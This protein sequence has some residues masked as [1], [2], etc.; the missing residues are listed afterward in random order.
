[1]IDVLSRQAIANPI[2][3]RQRGEAYMHALASKTLMVTIWLWIFSGS[4]ILFEPSFYEILLLPALCMAVASRMRLFSSTAPLLLLLLFFSVFGVIAAFQVRYTPLTDALIFVVVTI[5][6]IFTA[7]FAANFIAEAPEQRVSVIR[8]AYVATAVVSAAIGIFAYLGVLPNSEMFLRYDRAKA[9]FKDPNV[10]GPFL[11]LPAMLVLRDLFLQRKGQLLNGA[12][13]LLLMIG[14]FVSF[15]RAAWGHFAVSGLLV[16]V[17]CFWLEAI[18]TE[19]VRMMIIALAGALIVMISF[20]GLLSVPEIGSLFEQRASATQTYD[21]GET[22]R[23]GRQGYAFDLALTH[24]WGLGPTEFPHLRIMEQPH[25]TYVTVLHAYGWGGG[26]CYYLIVLLTLWRGL[27]G[28]GNPARRGLL[29]PVIAVYIPL[30]VQSAI[31]DTDH[32]RHYFLIVG[33]IWGITANTAVSVTRDPSR[34]IP[35]YP[36]GRRKQTRNS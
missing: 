34:L 3:A 33:L 13:V 23:F 9:M 25:N 19:K 26:L 7:F 10:Y 16:F 6:L 21:T 1:M 14:V 12:I 17:L 2:L 28:L 15:S 4:F 29:I 24:P 20:A 5:Y 8:N 30:V 35:K 11:I 36:P 22:G 31:I 27:Q 32:W 18:A